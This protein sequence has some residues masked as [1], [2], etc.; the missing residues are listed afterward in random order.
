M[1][2]LLGPYYTPFVIREARHV[3]RH[4]YQLH[5]LAYTVNRILTTMNKVLSSRAL[6]DAISDINAIAIDDVFGVVA[7]EKEVL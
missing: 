6:D 7:D 5:V 1:A 4:G 2:Q 3:L